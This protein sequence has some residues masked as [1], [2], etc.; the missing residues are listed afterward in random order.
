MPF[1]ASDAH[2]H[3]ER[4]NEGL[5]RQEGQELMEQRREKIKDKTRAEILLNGSLV[6][7][8]VNYLIPIIQE[9]RVLTQDVA[10]AY[11][12]VAALIHIPESQGPY[13]EHSDID[14]LIIST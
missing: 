13:L 14:N 8:T 6:V 4:R 1:S 5:A 10:W 2:S 3:L 11:G 7:G 9:W 12:A